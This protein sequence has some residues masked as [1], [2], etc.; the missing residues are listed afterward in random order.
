MFDL[1]G[2]GRTIQEKEIMENLNDKALLAMDILHMAREGAEPV[3]CLHAAVSCG[4]EYSDALYFVSRVLKLST[5]ALNE[6]VHA[7]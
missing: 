3:D 4:M 5:K 2:E 7:H 1:S 6:L